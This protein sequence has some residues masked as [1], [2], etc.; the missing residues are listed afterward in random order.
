[1]FATWWGPKHVVNLNEIKCKQYV[2]GFDLLK[3]IP[4]LY[5][6]KR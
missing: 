6:F 2:L 3:F 4:Y 5:N 1:M